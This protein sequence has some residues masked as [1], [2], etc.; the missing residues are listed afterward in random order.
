MND[1]TPLPPP[2]QPLKHFVSAA[3]F[4]PALS[5][6]MSEQQKRI[7]MAS[8]WKLMWWK[9]KR[10]RLALVSGIFLAVLYAMIAISEFLAPYNLHTRHM[11]FIYTPPQRVHLFHEGS[12]VGPFVYGRTM[13]LDMDTLKR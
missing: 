6:V 9:F 10:H 11:D 13:N 4:D 2:G 1:M 7:H 8:Q 12:F 3:P 5:E